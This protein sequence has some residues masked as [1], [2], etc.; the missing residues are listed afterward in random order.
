M[1]RAYSTGCPSR[2]GPDMNRESMVDRLARSVVAGFPN[3]V[4]GTVS[5]YLNGD[6]LTVRAHMEMPVGSVSLGVLRDYA[7]DYG[8]TMEIVVEGIWDALTMS[9]PG[10]KRGH[11]STSN[12]VSASNKVVGFKT[13]FEVTYT[14]VSPNPE[15]AGDIGNALES[16]VGSKVNLTIDTIQ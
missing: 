4:E 11:T 2:K 13:L 16:E 7:A 9:L 5:L 8:N 6:T 14:N 3:R 10:A 15:M 12:S 1:R